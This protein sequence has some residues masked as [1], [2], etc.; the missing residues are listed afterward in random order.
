MTRPDTLLITL[1]RLQRRVVTNRTEALV[2]L[3]DVTNLRRRLN[4]AKADA[5]RELRA[6]D[7]NIAAVAAYTRKLSGSAR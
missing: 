1:G 2:L 3:D 5:G 7:G 4:D 6:L